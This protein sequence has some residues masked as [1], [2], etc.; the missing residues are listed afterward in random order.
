MKRTCTALLVLVWLAAHASLAL[1]AWE[2][3]S[4][5]DGLAED[6][7]TCGIQDRDEV[8]WFGTESSG[9]SRYDGANWSTYTTAD[10]LPDNHVNVLFEDRSG[11]IWAGTNGGLAR[12][13]GRLWI[14]VS[15]L[16]SYVYVTSIAQDRDGFI[17]YTD[18]YDGV[19]RYDG[20]SSR[21]YPYNGTPSGPP[22]EYV[23]AIMFDREGNLWAG[24]GRSSTVARF[25]GAQW[26]WMDTGIVTSYG[27]TCLAADSSGGV[28]AGSHSGA[29]RFDGSTWTLYT[30]ADGL[31]SSGVQAITTDRHGGIW[32]A[33][34]AGAS[35]RHGG[36]WTTFRTADGLVSEGLTSVFEDRS[37]NLW[38]GAIGGAS[39][40]DRAA[41]RTFT[42]ADGLAG[43]VV[44]SIQGDHL[45][46]LWFGTDTFDFPRTAAL[47]RF[48]G[49]SWR[50]YTTA[51]GLGDNYVDSILEDHLGNV[52]FGTSGGVT[53]YDGA[54]WTTYPLPS[55]GYP[56]SV[57]TMLRE[58][59]QGRIWAIG[60]NGTFYFD[61][62]WHPFPQVFRPN[63]VLG[64]HLGRVWFATDLDVQV[65]D[66]VQLT[67]FTRTDGVPFPAYDLAED[68]TGGI[69]A[70]GFSASRFDGASW[71]RY[72]LADG[73][74]DTVI[75]KALADS[76][77]AVWF[78]TANHGVMRFD[79]QKWSSYAT[80]DGLPSNQVIS[81]GLDRDGNVLVGTYNGAARLAPDLVPPQTVI[82]SRP[83]SVS[84]SRVQS[85]SFVGGFKDIRGIEFSY[86]LNQGLWS[87]WSRTGFWV[88][89]NLSDGTYDF[90]VRARDRVG[91][92]DTTPAE[93]SFVID[94]TPPSP[95]ISGPS[96]GQ[97]VRDSIVVIGSTSDA[98]FRDSQ[99]EV[100][101][102]GSTV[103][104]SLGS[105]TRPV[106]SG[107]LGGW[108][109]RT[110]QDGNYDLRLT[111]TDSLGLLGTAVVTVVVDNVAPFADVTTPAK[112]VAVNGGDIFTTDAALHLYFPPHAFDQDALVTVSAS[113]ADTLASAAL[114]VTSGYEL[115]WSGGAL[116]KA[117]T[118]RLL[119]PG[120]PCPE[121]PGSQFYAVYDSVSAAGWQRLGGTIECGAISLS[122]DR[123][124]RYAV[125][126]DSGP[127]VG[128]RTLAGL[129]FTPRVFSPSTSNGVGIAF[130]LG[131]GAPVTIRVYSRSGRLLREVATERMMNAGEN[132]VRWDGM[133]RN[134]GPVADGLYLVTVEALGRTLRQTLAV[135]R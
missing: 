81:M 134:G 70:V 93:A 122:V 37:G 4:T 97:S 80:V 19:L 67:T 130:T 109:T 119:I 47:S 86:R 102:S 16:P 101:P 121:A 44:R 64:D 54:T 50:N 113:S 63:S 106:T 8:V 79:G 95:L 104:Q 53:R 107:T 85:V 115:S 82:A 32:F 68:G 51:D 84:S 73:L 108:N 46:N 52:W 22:S 135:A 71:R 76:S 60:Y 120:G 61:G 127:L 20:A 57:V 65:W 90:E 10:G 21:S 66:G 3:F 112:I 13:D 12:F 48:D 45:G 55:G 14:R 1:G 29:A 43:E 27:I 26:T 28:W 88:G 117:A 36:H 94:A 87:A 78:G 58:D 92:L 9:V 23:S 40:F 116:R 99:L 72:G 34:G 7:V 103:W 74:V 125:F 123:P 5:G 15:D 38:F 100:R 41:S 2:S 118:M 131:Q 98:R 6:W 129:A 77:G 35:W 49:T 59:H 132:L 96:F 24:S 105:S 18:G 114:P 133:D 31:G 17:W 126:R 110:V 30:N 128:G 111:V 39:R 56:S 124:G 91:N 11:T 33:T 83:P 62:V 25:D 89:N 75:V 69:W 42:V